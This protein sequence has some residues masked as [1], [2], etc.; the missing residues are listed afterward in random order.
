MVRLLVI[1]LI[2]LLPT[3]F[4]AGLIIWAL[5]HFGYTP[6]APLSNAISHMAEPYMGPLMDK[7]RG[8]IGSL[9]GGPNAS[10]SY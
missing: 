9:P 4:F 2:A 8:L 3:I 7:I 10:G 1:L 5:G 6:L